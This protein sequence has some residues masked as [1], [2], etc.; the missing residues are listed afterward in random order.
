LIDDASS[1]YR[2]GQ[3]TSP[4]NSEDFV[5]DNEMLVQCCALGYRID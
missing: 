2:V 4:A 5:F 1:K 3:L